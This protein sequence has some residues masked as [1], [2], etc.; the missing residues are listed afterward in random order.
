VNTRSPEGSI[1]LGER[2]LALLQEGSFATTYKYAVLLALIDLCLEKCDVDGTFPGHLITSELAEKVIELYWSHT[3]PF[4]PVSTGGPPRQSNLGQVEI[5]SAIL[6]FRQ[7]EDNGFALSAGGCKQRSPG[8]YHRLVQQVEW[9]LIEMPLPR[10]QI[11]GNQ[12]ER[13]LYDIGWSVSEVGEGALRRRVVRY[14]GGDPHAFDPTIRLK[15]GVAEH[16]VRLNGLL[17]PLIHRHWALMVA[18][19]NR[20]QESQL[21]DYL[22]GTGRADLTPVRK[23]L[24]DLQANHCFYCDRIVTGPPEVDH[25]IPWSRYPDNGLTNLVVAD[26]SCNQ[27]KRDFLADRHHLAHWLHRAVVQAD[28]LAHIGTNKA[29]DY[30]PARTRSAAQM[31]YSTVPAGS[32]L[33]HGGSDFVA[34]DIAELH[35]LFRER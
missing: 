23:A 32:A 13:F 14:Q 31:I 27:A 19:I 9:K 8:S 16:L 18:A 35:R 22:F 10:L 24:R 6:R 11:L 26:R 30:H 2:V 20:F 15:P 17:R 33:W 29:W 12:E 21:E 34:A 3:L 5:V 25:F 1:E 28:A 7:Q 4:E